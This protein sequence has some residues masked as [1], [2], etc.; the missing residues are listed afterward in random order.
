MSQSEYIGK[1]LERFRIVDCKPV[2]TPQATYFILSQKTSP[3]DD[4]F[5]N[6][7]YNCMVGGL[8][9]AMVYTRPDI[10][11]AVGVVSKYTFS[12]G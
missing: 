11:Y 3:K 9:Y 5:E 12:A 4:S 8:M 2:S 10:V 6:V 1:A 7:L